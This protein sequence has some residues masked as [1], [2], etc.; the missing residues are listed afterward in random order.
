MK[1]VI[2]PKISLAILARNFL[3]FLSPCLGFFVQVFLTKSLT[4]E[5]LSIFT[6]S[7]I[8][9]AYIVLTFIS[10]P[11]L[12]FIFTK[13]IYA[14]D[15]T[16]ETESVANKAVVLFP[17]LSIYIPCALNF[18]LP[19]LIFS[20]KGVDTN[21]IIAATMQI[22]GSVGILSLLTYIVFLQ[23]FEEHMIKLPLHKKYTS[24]SLVLRSVLVSFFSV[25]GVFCLTIA[26]LI[27]EHEYN[28]LTVIFM[29]FVAMMC[30][31]TSVF[32]QMKG[33]TKRLRYI[34]TMTNFA[35]KGDYSQGHVPVVSRD[36]FGLV[37]RDM[38][39]FLTNTRSLVTDLK[40]SIE[41]SNVS[42]NSLTKSILEAE[43]RIKQVLSHISEVKNEMI[44]QSAG[45][46]QTQATVAQIS[47]NINALDKHIDSQASSV[48]H[49]SA[50]IEQMIANIQSVT[51]ILEKNNQLVSMLD[52]AALRGQKTVEN[53]VL[54]S[55]E[56]YSESEGLLEAS[57]IIK[58][59]ADQ[60]N[61]LAMNAAIEAA[62]AGEA[63]KGFAVVADEIR[64]LAEDAGVQSLSIT[65]RLKNLGGAITGILDNTQDVEKTFDSIFEVAQSI[66]TQEEMVMS[67]M[68]EQNAG[69][70]QV[71]EA[72][73][74][75][76]SITTSVQ[77]GSGQ[78]LEGSKEV[79]IEMQKLS[80]VTTSINSIMNEMDNNASSLTESLTSVNESTEMN[81]SII[82][83]LNEKISI[84]TV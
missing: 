61:L 44:N 38:N 64:K 29:S 5:E 12:F 37:S 36:E 25:S 41:M 34:Q 32:L 65:N 16:I 22:F 68:Q 51:R 4:P 80:S 8:F 39:S 7:P 70:D 26:P 76:K 66:K 79:A 17:K 2:I 33:T 21:I 83:D 78:M 81:A 19:V 30:S 46:E 28:L 11:L 18:F 14:Y 57:E 56:I 15:G 24:M 74:T 23:S 42:A 48:M 6:S 47:D 20:G 59:I 52:E 31:I 84:F 58:H 13:K 82:N 72:M 27:A 60:T 54:S 43:E 1:N 49:A 73:N 35:A 50:A 69:N 67:A 53:A 71:L 77:D 40:E 45:V 10:S 9:A 75:I 63:G 62:H 3:I 55:K